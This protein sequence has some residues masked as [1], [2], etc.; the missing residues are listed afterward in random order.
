[1]L[2]KWDCGWQKWESLR[3]TRFC[4]NKEAS[5]KGQKQWVA[6]VWEA[7][8]G[9]KERGG[10]MERKRGRSISDKQ[11]TVEAFLDK[12]STQ[13]PLKRNGKLL[14]H[15]NLCRVLVL[16]P[17]LIVKKWDQSPCPSPGEW[18]S[19]LHNIDLTKGMN[20]WL[21][22]TTDL[23]QSLEPVSEGCTKMMGFWGK[24]NLW[25][26]ESQPTVSETEGQGMRK[27]V[28]MDSSVLSIHSAGSHSTTWAVKTCHRVWHKG[29]F[30]NMKTLYIKLTL[31]TSRESLSDVSMWGLGEH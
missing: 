29:E 6:S 21:T 15:E 27:H 24:S 16:A 25:G 1:M 11:W 17:F 9:K 20:N 13:H 23:F 18:M 31:K 19:R 30:Y 10:G 26:Q 14:A 12:A 7:N 5:R 4:K 22:Q 28:G 8:S 3:V 2:C